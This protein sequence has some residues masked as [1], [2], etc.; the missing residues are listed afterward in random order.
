MKKIKTLA[1]IM[2]ALI[3]FVT[4]PIGSP[5]HSSFELQATNANTVNEKLT[6]LSDET[7]LD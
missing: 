7:I 3:L 2:M 5:M 4:T 1:T 6:D